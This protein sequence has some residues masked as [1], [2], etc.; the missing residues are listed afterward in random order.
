MKLLFALLA[1][2]LPLAATTISVVPVFEPLSMHGTDVDDGIT[3]TG[4]ALQATVASRPMALTGA[5]P[6][7]LVEAI[8]SP[9]K[10]PSN[11]PSY[12]VDEVNLLVLCNIGITAEMVEEGLKVRLN[13]AHLAVPEGVDL[14]ARQVLKLALVAIRK[15]VEEYQKPQSQALKV[16]ITLEGVND[17][18]ASLKELETTY[19][20][21]EG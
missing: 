13:V 21:G 10:F 18:T 19:T 9:H 6:E 8:R 12:K 4:E 1:L 3:D 11:N 15:T 7:V 17:G 20:L 14:T 16:A 5:F 2:S